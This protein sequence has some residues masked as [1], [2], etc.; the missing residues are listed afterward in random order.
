MIELPQ[1]EDE[2]AEEVSGMS[3]DRKEHL[4]ELCK[5]NLFFLTKAVLGHKDV[6]IRTHGAFCRFFE[7]DSAFRRMALMP[8]LHLKTTIATE[9]DAIR[10]ALKSNGEDRILIANEVLKNAQD[11]VGV[12]NKHFEEN[13]ILRALFSDLIP[14]RFSGPGVTWS[15]SASTLIRPRP[16]KEP[17]FMAIGTGGAAVSKHF[18]R[19]KGDDLIG[20]EA[21]QSPAEMAHAIEWIDNME[22]LIVGADQTWIDW[23]GTRWAKNDAYGHVMKK[24][25]S[26]LRVFRRKI[27]EPN[28]ESGELEIIFPE[29]VN[30]EQIE[31]LM[32]TPHIFA[33]QYENDP[34]SELSLDFDAGNLREYTF[35]PDGEIEYRVFGQKVSWPRKFL[36][37]VIAVDPNSG[38]KTS[39]DE[40]AISVVGM[41]PDRRVFLLESYN[42]RPDPSGFVD[43]IYELALKWRPSVIGIEKAGQQNTRHYFFLK[44][45]EHGVFFRL[46]DLK[47]ENKEKDER[48]RTA[49]QPIINARQ[50]YLLKSQTAARQQ[51]GDFPNT[52]LKDVVDSIAYSI[53]LLRKPDD[54]EELEAA[55]EAAELV[56]AT[57]NQKTGW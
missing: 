37:I 8:R 50:L 54:P 32:K 21:F 39:E 55:N 47:P 14:P 34:T 43:K 6:N 23:I 16:Y 5:E 18:T 20:L 11:I 33:A 42:G 2:L 28:P 26:R 24:Y 29:K 25:G 12:I 46:E 41:A 13:K 31:L 9:A 7:D 15:N 38:S 48:I 53:R 30:M 10:C 27:R 49:L 52:T 1:S 4:R 3:S 57:R 51:I 45:Q 19:I 36:H 40:A 44:C 17:T 56:L 22:G 35:G